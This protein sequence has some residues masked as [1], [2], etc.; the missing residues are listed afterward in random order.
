MKA[1]LGIFL[2]ICGIGLGG[3]VGIWLLFIGGI[4][5]IIDQVRAVELSAVVVAFGVLKIFIAGFCG[6]LSSMILVAPG[7]ALIK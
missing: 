2:V 6:I 7:I 3:Y 1:V 4:V 5:Q